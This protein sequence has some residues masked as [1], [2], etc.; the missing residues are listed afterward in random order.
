MEMPN[1]YLTSLSS[2]AGRKRVFFLGAG[3][4]VNPPTNCPISSTLINKIIQAIAPSRSGL[5]MLKDLANPSR[6]N[7]RNPG[8]YIRFE[9]LL[10]IIQQ[11]VDSELRLLEFVELFD[12]PNALHR[13][14]AQRAMAGDVII[15]T[16]FDGL[17][18]ESILRLGGHPISVCTIADFE[19]WKNIESHKIPVYKIH[20]SYK[21]YDGSSANLATET[22]QATLSS[23]SVS[24]TELLLPEAKRNFFSDITRGNPII[25]CGYSGGDDLDVIPTLK[26]LS[27]HSLIW[28]SHG[29]SYSHCRDITQQTLNIL[30]QQDDPQLS[31]RDSFLKTQLLKKSYPVVICEVDTPIFLMRQ[32]S[33]DFNPVGWPRGRPSE[34][35]L[36]DFLNDWKHK[37]VDER[38][39]GHLILGQILF[40]LARFEE[41]YQSYSDAWL[42]LE[43]NSQQIESAYVARMLSRI[44]VETD[45]FAKAEEW[46]KRALEM[47]VAADNTP[48]IA[49]CLQ[50]YGWTQYK[51][52][53]LNEALQIYERADAVCRQ[54]KLDRY[55]SYVIH[56]TGVIYQ[57]LARYREAVPL[58]QESINLSTRDGD[59]RHVMFSFHQLGTAHYD[60]GEFS[61]SKEYHLKAMEI[62]RVIGDFAQM[63][64]SE[65]ELGLLDFL[66][67]KLINSICRFRRGIHIAKKTGRVE[68]I[69]MDLQHIGIAYMEGD[70]LETAGKYLLKAKRRYESI[71]DEITL[72]ELQSYLAEYYLRVE[73]TEKALDAA[74]AGLE[75]ATRKGLREYESRAD[76]M[77]GLVLYTKGDYANGYARMCNAIQAAQS[78]E[79]MAL[80]LD[81]LYLCAQFRVT[82]M[83][84]EGMSDLARWALGTYAGIANQKRSETLRMF[85]REANAI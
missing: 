32:F 17:I 23:L 8:D 29:G 52:G 65:H 82:E 11:I 51:R 28:F 37:H 79:F 53:N 22:V 10:D 38:H 19:S 47:M 73:D 60:L 56:D 58:Y 12:Q 7:K 26:L 66:S 59:I 84:C 61:Q 9:L 55:L 54:E 40:S 39:T 36:T 27:P 77:Q 70:K 76:F 44:A 68:F 69:A 57:S 15:T 85:L 49:Q 5:A 4:S 3:I 35:T 46:G 43:P 67:G 41:S 21:R 80:L 1:E 33:Q 45:R 74:R 63:D 2:V 75:I 71:G 30:N 13:L 81:Q 20:G 16:N 72:S 6:P 42:S 78:E 34:K 62:A 50:Q 83:P 25:V 18:E 48:G 24:A 64:N 14:F 31:S